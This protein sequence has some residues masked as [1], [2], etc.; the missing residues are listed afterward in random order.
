MILLCGQKWLLHYLTYC[1]LR[2]TYVFWHQWSSVFLT[3]NKTFFFFGSQATAEQSNNHS[4]SKWPEEEMIF[5][6]YDSVAYRWQ[7]LHLE[8][9]DFADSSFYCSL[10]PYREDANGHSALC[11][12]SQNLISKALLITTSSSAFCQ[13]PTDCTY[14]FPVVLHSSFSITSPNLCCQKWPVNKAFRDLPH[15]F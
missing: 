10:K 11:N 4:F 3:S 6:R 12:V 9:W 14:R 15:L 5:C 1:V 2:P 7:G 13:P 8:N